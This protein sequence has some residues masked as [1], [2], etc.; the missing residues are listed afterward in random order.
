M[1]WFVSTASYFFEQCTNYIVCVVLYISIVF[2]TFGYVYRLE[3]RGYLTLCVQIVAEEMKE[4][5]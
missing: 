3:V 2:S 5:M 4:E 1:P